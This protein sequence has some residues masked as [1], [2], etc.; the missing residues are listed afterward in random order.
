MT[1]WS[2]QADNTRRAGRVMG[3]REGSGGG[4]GWPLVFWPPP[5]RGH[6]V[7]P[8]VPLAGPWAALDP[9]LA[10]CEGWANLQRLAR[11]FTAL[12]TSTQDRKA[13]LIGSVTGI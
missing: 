7:P 2:S 13:S 3:V 11:V 5:S 4:G 10:L 8:W 1:S 9:D 12:M 6:P